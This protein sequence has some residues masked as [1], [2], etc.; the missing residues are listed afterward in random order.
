M[1]HVK[2]PISQAQF[3]HFGIQP[4]WRILEVPRNNWIQVNG[5]YRKD[6]T[7][8]VFASGCYT[9]PKTFLDISHIAGADILAYEEN[10]WV[11]KGEG[12]INI[13][14]SIFQKLTTPKGGFDYLMHTFNTGSL[15]GH[16]PGYESLDFYLGKVAESL[17]YPNIGTG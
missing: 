15:A 5:L 6:D 12:Q 10:P 1:K 11:E 2:T 13:Y 3:D 7:F 9:T 4:D 16:W 8:A 14:H 17:R